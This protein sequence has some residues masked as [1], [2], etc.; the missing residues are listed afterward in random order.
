MDIVRL[1]TTA[2]AVAVLVFAGALVFDPTRGHDAK[3]AIRSELQG[4]TNSADLTR[5]V[6]DALA[7]DDF[8]EAAMYAQIASFTG[9]PLA[10]ETESQLAG[11]ET[12]L[13]P[14]SRGGGGFVDGFTT[15]RTISTT[16]LAGAVASDLTMI[17]DIRDISSEGHAFLTGRPY[18]EL[19]LG[20]SVI[21]VA[22]TGPALTTSGVTLPAKVGVS[23]LKVASRSQTLT[24]AYAKY[25]LD[26]VRSA[27]GMDALR[28][29]LKGIDL[30]DAVAARTAIETFAR[31][32]HTATIFATLSQIESMR[33]SAGAGEAVRLLQYVRTPDDLD[34]LAHMT[35]ILGAKTRG[36]IELTRK[37][38]LG[39][40][41][42]SF[43]PAPIIFENFAS[44]AAWAASLFI[45]FF[46]R[47]IFRLVGV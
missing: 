15:G 6:D 4:A 36:V 13:H 29:S 9:I 30:A 5:R 34:E 44:L 21:G 11:Q 23:V 2:F 37:T 31:R 47:K 46:S 25:L 10:P 24:E 7:R 26:T 16:A 17:G 12:H 38:N 19:V 42:H 3:S 20:L 8:D 32:V 45:L 28:V 33:S 35:R 41:K 43:S 39:L 22:L 1:V 27:V 40:F 18:D 14:I